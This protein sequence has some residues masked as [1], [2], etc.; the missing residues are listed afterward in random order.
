LSIGQE[1]DT[2]VPKKAKAETP[3]TRDKVL[4][5]A[6]SL[7]DTSGIEALSMR[8]L[9]RQLG[10]EAMSLYN[11]VAN[12][13]DLLDGMVDMVIDEIDLPTLDADWRD[14]MRARAASARA[15]FTRHPWAPRLID[16][17]VNG[18]LGRL[19]YFEA[20]IGVLRRAGFTVELAA[21]AFSLID[22]YI[23]GFSR[24]SLNIASSDGGDVQAA[25]AFFQALPAEEFPY[26][27]EMAATQAASPGYDEA[28]DFVFGLNLIL[29]GLQRVLVSTRF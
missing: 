9:G 27:A 10:V 20:V 25:E 5:V 12:K 11:Y 4:C 13:D 15:A 1:A 6:V 26:L 8:A 28:A 21:R 16:S 3:L 29:D 22:S 24:Q 17:R 19:R 14:A 23:Y 18:G 2:D 7:A